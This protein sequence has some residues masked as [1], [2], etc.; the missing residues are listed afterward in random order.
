M[1][2]LCA[3][4]VSL[5][6]LT[7][8]CGNS[9]EATLSGAVTIDGQPAKEGSIAFFPADGQSRTTGAKI[10]EGKYSAVVPIGKAR[11]EIRVPKVVGQRKLYDTPNSETQPLLQEMLPAKYNNETQLELDVGPGKN[12]KNFDLKT[13]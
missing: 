7:T 8:G 2:S 3:F 6:L 4:S 1:K 12:E 13:K 11:I 5:L 10:V 9:N